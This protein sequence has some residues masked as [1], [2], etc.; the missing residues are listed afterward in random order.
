M[1]TSQQQVMSL[2]GL[3]QFFKKD[4]NA[5]RKGEVKFTCGFVLDVRVN[6]VEISAS[7]R[8]SM[9]DRILQGRPDW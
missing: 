1:A 2:S 9:K 5:I 8:A 3:F 4:A 6:G 7:V